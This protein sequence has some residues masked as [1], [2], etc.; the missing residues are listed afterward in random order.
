MPTLL[1]A[2]P[3]LPRVASSQCPLYHC[4]GAMR[5]TLW[6]V[7]G[8]TCNAKVAKWS[9]R[10]SSF[11]FAG[12]LNKLNRMS[13]SWLLPRI[14]HRPPHRIKNPSPA[15]FA[16]VSSPALLAFPHP[17]VIILRFLHISCFAQFSLQFPVMKEAANGFGLS[18]SLSLSLCPFSSLT[19]NVMC[20]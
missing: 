20:I 12:W 1:A 4:S 13:G 15:A 16:V 3:R 6:D 19:G 7:D 11:G 2:L 9:C 17:V 5:P 18:I 8:P 14:P 10:W